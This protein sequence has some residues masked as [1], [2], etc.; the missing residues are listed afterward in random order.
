MRGARRLPAAGAA[1]R[2]AAASLLVALA[3]ACSPHAAAQSPDAADAPLAQR[4]KAAFLYRFLAYVDWPANAF[5][6]SAS[7]VVIGVAGHDRDVAEV[8]ATIGERL[9]NGRSVL[10]RRVREADALS[11]THV[12]F[13][14][15]A[16]S[17]RTAAFA[18]AARATSTLVVTEDESAFAQGSAI[19]FRIVDGRVRFDI[20][21][22]PAERAGLRI[23]SRLL[24]V[25][26]TVRTAP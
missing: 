14:T 19:N 13:V 23:S 2:R 3:L 26:Q 7:P 15:R 24:A 11:G 9:V 20:A 25:A 21:L 6:D 8:K 18:Q 1:M 10:V 16:E 5:A 22:A 17:A 12:L 4:V